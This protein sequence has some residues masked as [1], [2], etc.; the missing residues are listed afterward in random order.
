[1]KKEKKKK[2]R[3]ET[4]SETNALV[5]GSLRKKDIADGPIVCCDLRMSN[6]ISSK[7]KNRTRTRRERK[8]ASVC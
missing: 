3:N 2:K 4:K 8:A 1:V 7:K 5:M 6:K